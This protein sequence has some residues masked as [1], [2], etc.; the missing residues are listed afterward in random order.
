VANRN[1]NRGAAFERAVK[2]QLESDG[3]YV[4]RAAGSHGLVDLLAINVDE[5]RL[6]QC[7]IGGAISEEDRDNLADLAEW[8][9]AKAYLVQRGK[10]GY[11]WTLLGG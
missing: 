11:K 5:V 1:Y 2:K 8:C 3:F 10:K 6:I 9:K 7:K 4:V